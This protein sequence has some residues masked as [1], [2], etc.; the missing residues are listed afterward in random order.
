MAGIWLCADCHSANRDG[1]QRCYKCRTPRSRGEVREATAAMATVNA[2][3]ATAHLAAAARTGA[4]YR[5]TWVLAAIFLALSV[6]HSVAEYLLL[7]V[8]LPLV[9][10]DGTIA[11]SNSQLNQVLM[12]FIWDGGS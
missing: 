2:R 8:T 11:A 7:A 4:R 9:S 1:A 3:Q 5:P 10:A 12:L 6:I